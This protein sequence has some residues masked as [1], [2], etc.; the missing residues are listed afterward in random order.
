MQTVAWQYF[1]PHHLLSRVVGGIAR[2]KTPSIKNTLIHAFIKRYGVDMQLAMEPDYKQY[3]TFNAFFTRA[4]RPDVRPIASG[5]N[6]I[7]SP[8]DGAVSQC[9]RIEAGRIFQAK[10]HH[11]DV[12]AL[13]GGDASTASLF[14]HGHFATIYLSPKDYHRVHMPLSG[15]LREMIYIPG[16]LFSVN[17]VSVQHIPALFA[18]NERVVA[19]FDSE[20]GPFAVVLVGAMIV[21]SIETVWSGLVAPQRGRNI[22]RTPYSDANI[23]LAKGDEMGRFQL[24]STAII[25]FSNQHLHWHHHVDVGASL[26]MGQALGEVSE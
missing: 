16:R 6:T 24:G 25:L 10:G 11:Y 21:A 9:G 17:E 15:R 4:L 22:I 1:L 12:L 20:L 2:C 14:D 19:L 18:K 5:A 13:L 7:V 8:A 3:P 26:V 23:S